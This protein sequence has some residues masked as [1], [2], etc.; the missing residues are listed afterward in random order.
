MHRGRAKFW[1]GFIFFYLL[2][3][4]QDAPNLSSDHRDD[5]GDVVFESVG[6]AASS[7]DTVFVKLR[8]ML[9]HAFHLLKR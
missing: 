8:H 6:E 2:L 4:D 7:R 3:S 1:S 5:G 9:S